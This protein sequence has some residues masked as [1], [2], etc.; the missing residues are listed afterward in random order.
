MKKQVIWCKQM[1][2]R[3]FYLHGWVSV[4]ICIPKCT[5]QGP[6]AGAL[7]WQC[8]QNP[9][10]MNILHVTISKTTESLVRRLEPL[11]STNITFVG[12][13]IS[14]TRSLQ[15]LWD[16]EKLTSGAVQR[17]EASWSCFSAWRQHGQNDDP[18]RKMIHLDLC[19]WKTELFCLL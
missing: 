10:P 16:L 7:L 1:S 19:S 5:Q 6:F 12:H 17:K 3:S 9:E 4:W 11:L 2:H 15:V 8:A 13:Q 18:D 14:N